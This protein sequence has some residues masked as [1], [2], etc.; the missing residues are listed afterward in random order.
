MNQ[1]EIE[2][3]FARAI[4]DAGLGDAVIPADGQIHRFR[5]PEDRA[6]QRTGWAVLHADGVPGGTVGDWRTGERITWRPPGPVG[7][8]ELDAVRE[9]RKRRQQED[10]ERHRRASEKA[11][12]RYDRLPPAP[13]PRQID[14]FAGASP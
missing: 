7:P 12:A 1:H 5:T 11:A 13:A 3:A 2:S 9:A 4:A 10:E 6:N 14:L 8:R